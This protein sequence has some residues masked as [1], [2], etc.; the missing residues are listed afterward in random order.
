MFSES[1]RL[2]YLITIPFGVRLY[3]AAAMVIF[4]VHGQARCRCLCKFQMLGYNNI[5][6][7]CMEAFDIHIISL[8]SP[9]SPAFA[10]T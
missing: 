5:E 10:S 1:F 9:A 6:I 8:P 4:E 3:S 2:V 7:E